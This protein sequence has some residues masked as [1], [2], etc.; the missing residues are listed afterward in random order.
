VPIDFCIIIATANFS[1]SP[2]PRELSRR[3]IFVSAHAWRDEP[4]ELDWSAEADPAATLAPWARALPTPSQ[5][6]ASP[7]D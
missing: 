5:A 4:P 7:P 6:A 3:M 2:A 1:G